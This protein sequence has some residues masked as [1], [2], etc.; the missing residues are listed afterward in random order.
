[1]RRLALLLLLVV[2]SFAAGLVLT[3]H[4]RSADVIVAEPQARAAGP[5][6]P[7]APEQRAAP[8]TIPGPDF[9]AVAAETVKAVTNISATQYAQRPNSPFA[10]DPFSAT[11]SATTTRSAAA[12][13]AS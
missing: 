1:V 11:S 8:L 7:A 10:N 2:V 5:P 4:L 13:A 12:A 9:T 3:G 6:A